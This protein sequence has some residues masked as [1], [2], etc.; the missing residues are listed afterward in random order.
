M[1]DPPQAVTKPKPAPK[2][3]RPRR[4]LKFPPRLKVPPGISRVAVAAIRAQDSIVKLAVLEERYGISSTDPGR[5]MAL[6]LSVCVEFVPGF[7]RHTGGGR[8][9][10]WDDL[11]LACLYRDAKKLT[12]TRR[13]GGER[14]S[15]L[16]ICRILAGRDPW[17]SFGSV[18]NPNGLPKVL[19]N[20]LQAAKKSSIVKV[21][22]LVAG[23]SSGRSAIELL[24]SFEHPKTR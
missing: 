17:R 14:D 16:D 4:G 24:A 11:W 23:R 19:Y 8:P 22:E 18:T 9:R 21:A 10:R 5:L 7:A 1:P 15:Q 2:A 12:L 3:A 20:Q 6:L 13:R